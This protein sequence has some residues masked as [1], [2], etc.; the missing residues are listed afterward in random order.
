MQLITDQFIESFLVR[1]GVEALQNDAALIEQF[2]SHANGCGLESLDNIT[3]K[4]I[5]QGLV[6]RYPD[7]FKVG[8]GL[9]G[10]GELVGK[11][12]Q[13]V[14]NL[15]KMG[16]GK[17]P[18]VLIKQ[19]KSAVEEVNKTYTNQTWLDDHKEKKGITSIAGITKYAGS[20]DDLNGLIANAVKLIKLYKDGVDASAKETKAWWDKIKPFE[21]KGKKAAPGSPEAKA[22]LEEVTKLFPVYP[23]K[24]IARKIP[25]S[26]ME[27]NGGK[28]PLLSKTEVKQVGELIVDLLESSYDILDVAAECRINYGFTD[29]MNDYVKDPDLSHALYNAGDWEG[30][31]TSVSEMAEETS[32]ILF[33]LA[34]AFEQ[35]ITSSIN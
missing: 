21:A 7:H 24:V 19:T 16:R 12:K 23:E 17:L 6:A 29:E 13:A 30:L 25:V 4:L 33:K 10:L 27:D 34:Q 11:I 9:E 3:G 26:A 20:A 14:V 2:L 35:Y 18:P 15:T 5:E 28:L 8:S 22:L 32:K 31:N 1:S